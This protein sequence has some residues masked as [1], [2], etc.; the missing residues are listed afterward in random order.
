MKNRSP[1][2]NPGGGAGYCKVMPDKNQSD[3][4]TAFQTANRPSEKA[5]AQARH[6]FPALRPRFGAGRQTVPKTL[7]QTVLNI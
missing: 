7:A 4:H 2:K 1:I 6:R 3:M 5:A